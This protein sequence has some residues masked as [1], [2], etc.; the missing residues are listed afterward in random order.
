MSAR[1]DFDR[2]IAM[3]GQI[4]DAYTNRGAA[5]LSLKQADQARADV[6][7]GLALGSSE[8]KRAYFNRGTA[9][10][11]LGDNKAA[12]LD[13]LKASKLDPGWAAPKSELTRFSVVE[14]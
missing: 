6:D 4:G 9:D 3:N 2:T 5:Q 14:R 12:Y 10:E 8:P 1:E 11:V 13:F 7:R